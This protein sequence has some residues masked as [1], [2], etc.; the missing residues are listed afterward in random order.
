MEA[1][2]GEIFSI[3]PPILGNKKSNIVIK[4]GVIF[5]LVLAVFQ[6]DDFSKFGQNINDF[7]LPIDAADDAETRDRSGETIFVVSLFIFNSSLT[8][9][10]AGGGGI[11][12]A[13]ISSK[14]SVDII[15][16]H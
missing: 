5:D 1:I 12:K 4:I 3:P 8:S 9:F 15:S 2:L 11:I 10:L 14:A 16:F 6:N 13:D 7:F